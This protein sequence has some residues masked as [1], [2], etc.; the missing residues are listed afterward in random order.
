[1]SDRAMRERTAVGMAVIETRMGGAIL[2]YRTWAEYCAALDRL[3][4]RELEARS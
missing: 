2:R 4:A 3:L 1:M